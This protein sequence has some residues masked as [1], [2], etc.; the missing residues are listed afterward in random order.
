VIPVHPLR[1]EDYIKRVVALPGDTIEVVDGQII[2]NGTPIKR[3]VVPPV[4]IPFEPDLICRSTPL[5]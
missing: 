3:E 5:S 1:N 2:L 4:R